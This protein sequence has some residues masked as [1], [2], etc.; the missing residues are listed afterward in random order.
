MSNI[1]T[2]ASEWLDA[3]KAENAAK[4]R[5][6]N[7]ESQLCEA[8]DVKDEGTIT[9]SID[10]FKI[11]LNQRLSRKV[12]PKAWDLVRDK[13]P[14]VIWP[15]KMVPTVDLSM[16]RWLQNN[17]PEIWANIARAFTTSKQKVGVK[18]TND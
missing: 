3:K 15:V 18:V 2:I 4:E 6:I 7:L 9:H 13:C 17:E 5:R 16:M 10:G 1:A 14:E 12:D 11:Q 8:F